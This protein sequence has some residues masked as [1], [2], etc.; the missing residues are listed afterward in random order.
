M[1]AL[2]PIATLA[3]STPSVLNPSGLPVPRFVSLKSDEVNARVG[4]GKRYPIRHVYRRAGLPVKIIEEFAHW[5]KIADHEGGSGWVHKG[6]VDGARTALVLRDTQNLYA[7]PSAESRIVMRAKP[8]VI[9]PVEACEADWC[10]LSIESREGWIRKADMWGALRE[11]VF[12][13]E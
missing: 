9:A 5:R 2:F 1:A 10:A 13:G 8:M 11:E 4:P 3:E 7:K 12:A 6:M